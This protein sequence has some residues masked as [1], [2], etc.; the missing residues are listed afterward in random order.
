MYE[1]FDRILCIIY[2]LF[3]KLFSRCWFGILCTASCQAA[4]Y[5]LTAV[6][7]KFIHLQWSIDLSSDRVFC[8]HYV[9]CLIPKNFINIIKRYATT[10]IILTKKLEVL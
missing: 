8:I 6:D 10:L 5:N 3:N 7:K 2:S 1:N 4:Y 9:Q